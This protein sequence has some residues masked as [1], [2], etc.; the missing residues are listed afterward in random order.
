MENFEIVGLSDRVGEV[1]GLSD[2]Y[3][4]FVGLEVE[5]VKIVVLFVCE[6]EVDFSG[7]FLKFL[8]SLSNDLPG[9]IVGGEDCNPEVVFPPPL[10]TEL[11]LIFF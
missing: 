10:T 9:L 1:G 8:K 2:R 5:F 4:E 11:G 3:F 7:I 6:G